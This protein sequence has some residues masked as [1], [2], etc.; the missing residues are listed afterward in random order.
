LMMPHLV[1]MALA[2]LMLSPVTM[3]TVIP[4]LWHLRIASGTSSRTGSL[5]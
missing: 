3:R 4:A 2:V 5:N 1:A